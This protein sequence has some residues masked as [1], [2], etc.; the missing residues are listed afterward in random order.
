M[1]NI[2]QK[3]VEASEEVTKQSESTLICVIITIKYYIMNDLDVKYKAVI[4]SKK[5][6]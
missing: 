1:M 4:G 6:K 2:Q 5:V 3:C